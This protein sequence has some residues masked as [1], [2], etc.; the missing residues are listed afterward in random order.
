M[1]ILDERKL[2][3]MSHS[4]AQ[5]HRLGVR[6]GELLRSGD[7]VC[8]SGELGAGKTT[9]VAGVGRG[10]G[11]TQTVTSPTFILVNEYPRPGDGLTLYHIDCYRVEN[12]REALDFGLG[13]ILDGRGVAL[14][15]WA[16]R[17]QVV[18]PRERLWVSLR[19]VADTKRGLLFEA[20]GARYERLLAE[21]RRSAFGV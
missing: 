8:L 5:T 15:E 20:T 16:E 1:P 10:W 4:A 18:L 6:L 11:A 14:I 2:D 17:I 21:F 13:E 7:L 19:P 9:F 12:A 3:F